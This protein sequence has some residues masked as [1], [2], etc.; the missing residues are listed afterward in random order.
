MAAIWGRFSRNR[1]SANGGTSISSARPVNFLEGC[2]YCPHPRGE[3]F[4]SSRL[5]LSRFLLHETHVRHGSRF[6]NLAD[7][8][9]LRFISADIF[10]ER[11]QNAFG[12]RRTH[13]H[14]RDQL[15]LRHVWKHIDEVQREFFRIVM[16][17]YQVA[18]L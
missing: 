14:A 5:V 15:A 13:D 18:E 6:R 17:H 12:V 9:E 8:A 11:P 4:S 10:S 3:G 2:K 7:G 16:E 1:T